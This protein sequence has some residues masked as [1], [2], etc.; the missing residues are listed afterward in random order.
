MKTLPLLSLAATLGVGLLLGYYL[1]RPVATVQPVNSQVPTRANCVSDDCL[2]VDNLDYP[3]ATLSDSARTAL[4]LALA[5]EYKAL[6]VY[7]A[8]IAKFGPVRPFIMIKGAETQH[9]AS[10]KALY[11]KYGLALPESAKLTIVTSPST[12][13]EACEL[14]VTAEIANAA[15]YQDQLLPSVSAYP[16]LTAVFTNL[17]NAS[18]QKHLPAFNRCN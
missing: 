14:G 11:D 1:T 16:D 7:E 5:D 10:L 15:L 3:A 18:S 8:V 2:A 6:S 9:I 13:S 12:L 17:M 4:D